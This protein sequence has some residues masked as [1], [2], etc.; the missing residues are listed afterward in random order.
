[1]VEAT[2]MSQIHPFWVIPITFFVFGVA[3]FIADLL[4]KRDEIRDLNHKRRQDRLKLREEAHIA[5]KNLH[6]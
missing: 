5:I 2:W 3:A 4:T 1:M 6:R